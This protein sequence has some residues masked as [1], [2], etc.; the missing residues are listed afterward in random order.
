MFA[1]FSERT[2]IKKPGSFVTNLILH[3]YFPLSVNSYIMIWNLE[4]ELHFFP[5]LEFH[6]FFFF[7]DICFFQIRELIEDEIEFPFASKRLQTVKTVF[8]F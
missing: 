2:Y 5:F 6:M 1:L 8:L 4:T 7:F 3:E